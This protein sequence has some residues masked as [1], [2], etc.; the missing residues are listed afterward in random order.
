MSYCKQ[1]H[2]IFNGLKR[3]RYPFDE[4]D[5]P[6]NGIY[7]QFENG[8][9]AH[10]GDRIVRIGTH[11]GQGN[12]RQRLNE[13][14]EESGR[15]VFRRKVG[16]A[17]INKEIREGSLYWS[18]E[19]LEDW[20]TDWTEREEK[21]EK[22]NRSDR[23]EESERIV[24]EYIRENISFICIKVEDKEK[25]K[26]FEKRLI[27]TVSNCKEC[28]Q[29]KDWLGKYCNKDRVVKSG[30]WQEQG[31]WGENI[32]DIEFEELKKLIELTNECK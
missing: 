2:E 7:V 26:H 32:S 5:I 6:E 21:F 4:K 10:S 8:E 25:R 28:N 31:L 16:S 13:H 24:S 30:L 29:S 18:K 22:R 17:L 15:S 14:F 11:D 23:L 1:L 19:D 3:Y 27:S 9:K 12:L 20:S